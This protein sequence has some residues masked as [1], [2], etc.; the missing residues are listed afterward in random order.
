MTFGHWVRVFSHVGL[1]IG[2]GACSWAG[3]LFAYQVVLQW[4]F[5]EVPSAGDWRAVRYWSG[6]A[7]GLLVIPLW[8]FGHS[9]HGSSE[10]RRR[11]VLVPLA[12]AGVAVVAG[13]IAAPIL[14]GG[15]GGLTPEVLLFITLFGTAGALFGLGL[16]LA[17]YLGQILSAR[18][19]NRRRN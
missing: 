10:S 9:L 13:A 4:L 12:L 8:A 2:I 1:A 15:A 19:S 14:A 5:G 17:T 6:L 18:S 3:G 16:E 7:F 11:V